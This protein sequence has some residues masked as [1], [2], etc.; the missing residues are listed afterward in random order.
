MA[1]ED[2]GMFR[3][4]PG[5]LVLYPSDVVS[6]EHCVFLA[7]NWKGTAYIKTGRNKFPVIYS[8][9]EVFEVGKAKLIA[10]A[11]TDILTVVSSGPTLHELIK[12]NTSLL[13]QGKSIRL[14]DLFSVKPIDTDTIVKAASGTNNRV[15]VVED[16]YAEGGIGDAIFAACKNTGL[17]FWHK[18]IE[19]LPRSGEPDEL[20]ELFGLSAAKLE[21]LIKS[22]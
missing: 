14:I 5:S 2:V 10:Q 19:E 20:Y 16:H 21:E 9:D 1:L 17:K 22:I 3:S 7:A 4:I 12:V 8:K 6:A 11:E 13:K 15:L 18:F